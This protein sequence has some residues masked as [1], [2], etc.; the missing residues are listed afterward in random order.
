MIAPPDSSLV[1]DAVLAVLLNDAELSALCPDGVWWDSAN[2]DARRFVIVSLI[3]HVDEPVF[4]GR[5]WEDFTLLVKVVM[6]NASS[7]DIRA[8]ALRLDELLDDQPLTV[9]GYDYM[10]MFREHRIRYMEHD[11]ENAAIRWLHRGAHYR[12]LMAIP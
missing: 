7:V 3:A 6:L 9:E 12:V 10:A 11:V 8:A 5:A 1:E 2:V 4:G